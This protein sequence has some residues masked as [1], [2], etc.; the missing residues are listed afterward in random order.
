MTVFLP[1][2]L[3]ALDRFWE[4]RS[5]RRA[6]LVGLMLALQGLAS[7]YL[8]VITATT[9]AVAVLVAVLGGL[10]PRELLR[11]AVAFA[12]AGVLLWPVI[13]PY[14]RMRAFE[15][16]EFTMETVS[17]YAATL[18]SYAAAGTALWGPLSQRLLDPALTRDTLFPGLAVLVLGIVGLAVAPRRFRVVA[19]AASAAA[20]VLSLGPE[21]AIYRFLHENV[22]FLRGVRAL[23]RFALVPTLALAVLAGLALASRRRLVVLGA[24][25]LMMLESQNLPLRFSREEGPPPAARWLAGKAGAVLDL[26]LAVDDTRVMLDG[27][28]HGRPLVNGDS[29]F[30]PRPF[31]RAMELLQGPVGTDAQRFLRAVHVRHVVSPDGLVVGLPEVARFGEVGVYALP[32]DGPRAEVVAPGEPV[33]T[34]WAE[35]GLT[36]VLSAPRRVGRVAFEMSDE[37]WVARPRVQASMDGETWEPVDARGSLADATLSLYRDPRHARGEIRFAPRDVRFLRVAPAP[38]ARRGTFEIGP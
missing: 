17:I 25:V 22:V 1:F 38:S 26:P 28:A 19:V 34:L 4:R 21:T 11:L 24:L 23:A 31:D 29:G 10:R 30:I 35:E 12:G 14:L 36:L 20:I 9:L 5:L 27:L 2:A 32:E 8:G 16:V 13:H 18:P 37:A 3:L 7:I 33:A 15:G 6:L